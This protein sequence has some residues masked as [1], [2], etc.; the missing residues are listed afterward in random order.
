M[1]TAAQLELLEHFKLSQKSVQ[2]ASRHGYG[3]QWTRMSTL[4]HGAYGSVFLE[5]QS[6][7]GRL[8]AVKEVRK[9]NEINFKQEL[10][11]WTRLSRPAYAEYFGLF[12]GWYE[13]EEAN[14][15]AFVMEYFQHG[16][17]W[18]HM[19]LPLAE[20]DVKT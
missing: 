17:L 15:I 14:S 8:R 1:A 20:E 2:S 11:A 18:K 12:L 7:T 4:G 5:E 9:R 6:W 3:D 16:D 10:I 19:Q 13:E